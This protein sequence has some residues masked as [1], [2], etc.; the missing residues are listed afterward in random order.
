[1]HNVFRDR[2]NIRQRWKQ[3][4]ERRDDRWPLFRHAELAVSHRPQASAAP[5]ARP[6]VHQILKGDDPAKALL[7]KQ[8][9]TA[10]ARFG[11]R[12]DV[13]MGRDVDSYV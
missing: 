2:R 1:M 13:P 5:G 8:T 3:E 10:V 7:G 12:F 6:N 4:G 11:T 9:Q